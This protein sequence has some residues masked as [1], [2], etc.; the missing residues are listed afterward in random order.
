NDDIE[1]YEFLARSGYSAIE[2]A[3]TRI[4]HENPYDDLDS[5]RRYSDE[6]YK[7][8]GLSISSMQ[9][10]WYGKSDNLYSVDGYKNLMDYTK[11][12]IN[13][14]NAIHC[15]NLVLGSPK[16]RNIP[17]NLS[18][19]EGNHIARKFL[20]EIGKFADQ[21]KVKSALEP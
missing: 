4:F 7:N 11:K 9:S 10:I 12:A 15:K 16:N 8:F 2:I 5:A 18:L 3:P 20:I 13:L 21:N 6:L 14:S 1:M 19:N 17:R